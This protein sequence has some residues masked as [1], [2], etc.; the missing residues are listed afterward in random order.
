MASEPHDLE[1]VEGAQMIE[2]ASACPT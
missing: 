2:D 1:A